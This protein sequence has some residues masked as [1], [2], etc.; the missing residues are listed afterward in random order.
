MN[1]GFIITDLKAL[2][3][4]LGMHCLVTS[5][6]GLTIDSIRVDP[7]FLRDY[8]H[9]PTHSL[10]TTVLWWLRAFFVILVNG[11]NELGT[12]RKSG[13]VTYRECTFCIVFRPLIF[14]LMNCFRSSTICLHSVH[15]FEP[16]F[17][18]PIWNNKHVFHNQ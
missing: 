5:Y 2:V 11:L 7:N 6:Y 16:P 14:H 4:S 3:C 10:P 18:Y 15:Y 13:I 8:R 17:L 1:V 9:S 12:L